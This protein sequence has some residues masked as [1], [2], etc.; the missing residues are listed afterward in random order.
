MEEGFLLV[1]GVGRIVEFIVGAI[2][3]AKQ[4][5]EPFLH[6]KLASVFPAALYQ[7]MLASMPL[8]QDYRPMSGR[9]KYTRTD[10]G[11]G[12]RTKI[13]LFPEFIRHLPEAKRPVWRMVGRAL[14]S[15]EVREAFRQG[16]APAPAFFKQYE[17]GHSRHC[18]QVHDSRGQE[19]HHEAPATA[20]AIGA[21][22]QAY[23][24]VACAPWERDI[25]HQGGKGRSA[26]QQAGAL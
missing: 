13:D 21:M 2:G 26:V 6:L 25:V 20:H 11:S 12:T 16:L 3:A 14:C 4:D 22:M 5:A 1:S 19:Q 9:T 24:Q 18:S 17:Q 23:Q 7:A 8:P 15:P 10:D